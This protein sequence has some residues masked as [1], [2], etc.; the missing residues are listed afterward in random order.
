[1]LTQ[2]GA[3]LLLLQISKL[4]FLL[5]GLPLTVGKTLRSY[6]TFSKPAEQLKE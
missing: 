2:F 1:M 4:Q 6:E 3:Q 5:S